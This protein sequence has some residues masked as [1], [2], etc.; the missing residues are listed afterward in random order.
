MA[1]DEFEDLVQDAWDAIPEF[2]QERMDN[3]AVV[4]E[5][6]PTRRDLDHLRLHSPYELLGLY[7]G[8][9]LPRRGIYFSRPIMPDVIAIFMHPILAHCSSRF[10]VRGQVRET[11][12][13]EIG[14]YFGLDETEVRS[15]MGR[16]LDDRTDDH[17]GR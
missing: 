12:A 3:V 9:P 16:Y 8:V 10:E 13:H 6:W 11:L 17:T 2:F 15:A 5:D 7:R 14:H 4:V 1:R